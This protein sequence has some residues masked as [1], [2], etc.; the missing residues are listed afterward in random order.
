MIHKKALHAEASQRAAIQAPI[1]SLFEGERLRF[2]R[3]FETGLIAEL[4][5]DGKVGYHG[6]LEAVVAWKV[7]RYS[8]VQDNPIIVKSRFGTVIQRDM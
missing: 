5:L 1:S 8:V 3:L 7:I 2:D 6:V 4:V